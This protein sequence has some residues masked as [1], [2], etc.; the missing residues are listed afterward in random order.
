VAI[1][2]GRL[3]VNGH[4]PPGNRATRSRL[5][6]HLD[7][8]R[9]PIRFEHRMSDSDALM[10]HLEKD[11]LLRSTITVVWWLDRVPDR[12]R[13]TDRIERATRIIPRLRQRV[14]SNPYSIAPPR[15]EL[16][17]YFDVRFHVRWLAAPSGGTLRGVLDYAEP[18]AMQG[19]D[20]ARP[21]WELSVIEG[22]AGDKAAMILKVHHSLS[23]GVG[24]VRMTAALVETS[25]DAPTAPR[26]MP[27][28][29]AGRVLTQPERVWDALGHEWRRGLGRVRRV[30]TAVPE[31]LGALATEPVESAAGVRDLAASVGR[32]LRPATEPLSPLMRARSPS[33]RFDTL[34]LPVDGLRAAAKRAHC[35]M[36]DAFVAG[37]AGGLF[38]YHAAHAVDVSHLRIS[39][40]ISVREGESGRIAGN[41]FV[42]ARFIV[43]VGIADPVARMK[44]VHELVSRQRAEPALRLLDEVAAVLNR[45]PAVLA[46]TLFGAMLRGVD[47]VASNVPGPRFEVWVAGA[48][49]EGVVGFGPLAGAAA[50][51]T[52]FSYLHEAHLGI[53]TDPAAVPDSSVF[54]QALREAFDEVLRHGA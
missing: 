28:L 3:P 29:P 43:P 25:P 41:Q 31:A 8:V 35:T 27:R 20:R 11:P 46:T 45:L 30:A 48:R 32:L 34:A 53:G 1:C 52:L 47:F 16:D 9:D 49:L 12:D 39:M 33:V 15:W 37:V 17:P 22:L 6:Y 38:R 42:P 14:V 4:D 50:N 23:D 5:G 19:F 21:L 51:V 40:P 10:W 7:A 2:G 13:L 26:A 24:L 18:I 54:V 44:A 36:N